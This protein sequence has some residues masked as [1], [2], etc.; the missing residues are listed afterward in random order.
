MWDFPCTPSLSEWSLELLW[1]LLVSGFQKYFPLL[2]LYLST[3]LLWRV[4]QMLR[5]FPGSPIGD[6]PEWGFSPAVFLW[7]REA[8]GGLRLLREPRGRQT[9]WRILVHSEG[10]VA[11]AFTGSLGQPLPFCSGHPEIVETLKPD[12]CRLLWIFSRRKVGSCTFLLAPD[13][14]SPI[15]SCSLSSLRLSV[16]SHYLLLDLDIVRENLLF[17]LSKCKIT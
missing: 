2:L 17:V 3:F 13:C 1:C 12:V 9:T 4:S 11:P 15:P 16:H 7:R 5:S 6:S 14:G 8:P 10:R